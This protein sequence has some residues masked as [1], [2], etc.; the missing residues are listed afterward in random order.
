MKKS[1]DLNRTNRTVDAESER[2]VAIG[3]SVEGSSIVTGDENAVGNTIG[4]DYVA[5]NQN[6]YINQTGGDTALHQLRAPVIDFVGREREIDTLISAL[7]SGRHAGISG[8]GGI[9]KTEL[10]LL[11][12]QRVA[13]DYRDAQFFL[14]LRGTDAKPRPPE[15]VLASCI[16]AFIGAEASLPDDRDQL[17]QR[18]RSELSGKR[19]LLLLD[20]AFDNAQVQG[21]LPPAGSVV[22]V[23][24]RQAL[25]LPGI[26]RL[27]LNPLTSE[28]G[29]K[30]LLEIAAHAEPAAEEICEYCGYLPL[31]IRAAGSLLAVT[32][33]LDPVEYAVQLKDER[34]R[35]EHI[36]KEGVEIDVAASF[37]L[38]YER[39]AP[40]AQLVFRLLSVFPVTFD[41][42]AEEVVCADVD[43]KQLSDLVRRSLVEYDS[44][45][46]RYRLHDL[47]RVFAD[48]KLS[49]QEDVLGR[50]R[51]AMH[52]WS[53]LAATNKLYLE[54]REALIRGLALFDLEWTNIQ[55][56][57]AWLEAEAVEPDED[58]AP[59][60]M[61]YPDVGR[62]VLH[63]RLHV[64]EWI[65]WLEIA[66][67]MAQRL[68]NRQYEGI[69]FGNLGIAYRNLGDTKRA[70][71]F[72]EQDLVIVRELRDRRGEGVA[73]GSLGNVYLSSGDFQQA[74]EFYEQYL[75]IAREVGE[76]R[77]EGDVLSNLG[78]AY[79][80]LG[81]TER[82]I[83]FHEQSLFIAREL[84]NR[85]GEGISM[86]NLGLAYWDLGETERAIQFYEQS[87][88]I[89]RELRD[90]RGECNAL[91]NM[92]LALKQLGKQTQAI[93][94]GEESLAILEQIEDPNVA[95][96][97]AQLAKW[98][99]EN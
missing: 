56:G 18:Y 10:A 71:Q 3:D 74:I 97:R 62:Y 43:H 80:R 48:S 67:D 44:S 76:R 63:L 7:R 85:R 72:L 39:L 68:K 78:V 23:T 75:T 34:K 86:G 57:H 87:L 12:A 19:V 35:L 46:R 96:I 92:S 60:A 94:H 26:T 54:G 5:G 17:L 9:G 37:N 8:M 70:I 33:D 83:R 6:I 27:K 65:H 58:I 79:R 99:G 53:V 84:G 52:Y 59:L 31:A 89:A 66:L 41:A 64:R 30:L 25:T 14:S 69:M 51:H 81:D 90:R 91:W 77:H 82:A 11:V 55:A 45:T 20:N 47:V 73:L 29:Q 22:L 40:E 95:K 98:R 21:L 36:G 42:A 88:L 61:T 4:G 2:G 32:D 16:R 15:E 1:Q 24:S 50:K 49:E 28:E 13:N 93:Q 38:S